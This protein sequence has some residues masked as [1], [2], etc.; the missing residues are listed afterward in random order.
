M[1]ASLQ[2]LLGVILI[3]A[4]AYALARGARL[5]G[6]EAVR[7]M[8]AGLGLQFAVALVLLKLP[9]SKVIFDAAS[10]FVGVL[11]R[12]TAAGMQLVFGY[13]AAAPAP[14]DV[15][16]PENGYL[17]AFRALPL[18]LVMSALTRL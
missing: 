6:R 15:T 7:T 9:G 18:I 13:L 5:P 3:P 4:A 10:A 17:L 1:G 11:Q 14:F 16:H 2:S 12:A 8:A